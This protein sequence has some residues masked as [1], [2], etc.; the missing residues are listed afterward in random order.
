MYIDIRA[1]GKHQSEKRKSKI[2]TVTQELPHADKLH[3]KVLKDCGAG[4]WG[5]EPRSEA[6]QDDK[7]HFIWSGAGRRG[8]EPRSEAYQPDKLHSEV[9]NPR[10]QRRCGSDM[11]SLH[12]QGLE[13]LMPKPEPIKLIS[14]TLD[15]VLTFLATA[16][17]LLHLQLHNTEICLTYN[18]ANM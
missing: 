8:S 14:F 18:T 6:H 15:F 3:C 12:L 1:R 11:I 16:G 5:S 13:K 4:P 17:F 10:A 2:L 9:P 7:L